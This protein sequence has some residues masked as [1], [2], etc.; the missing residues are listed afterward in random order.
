[1][2]IVEIGDRYDTFFTNMNRQAS[3]ANKQTKKTKTKQNK[4]SKQLICECLFTIF[5][6][7]FSHFSHCCQ[8]HF[9][10]PF[11]HALPLPLSQVAACCEVINRND[12]L[13][14]GFHVLGIGHG[15]LIARGYIERCN[16]PP[17]HAYVSIAGPQAGAFQ[18][19]AVHDEHADYI[20]QGAAYEDWSQEYL[21]PAQYFK[22]PMK[23]NLYQA[24]SS[25][26]ADINNERPLKN[27]TYKER[28]ESLDAMVLVKFTKDQVIVPRESS[29]FGFYKP[30]SVDEV[31]EMK[32]TELYRQDFIGLRKLDREKKLHLVS[33]SC[34]FIDLELCTQLNCFLLVFVD[35][36]DF[37]LFLFFTFCFL[38]LFSIFIQL[39]CDAN[40]FLL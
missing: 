34:A 11:T 17:A 35:F 39:N 33:I 28:I 3:S 6:A 31:M 5:S 2:H 18:V 29:W 16:T 40:N 19:P 15:A 26:I 7:R 23:P 12:R 25:F 4:T 37:F 8:T 38:L 1:V 24:E 20:L 22:H 9:I 36:L 30:H 10:C 27:A 14:Q 21:A 32:E 13:R